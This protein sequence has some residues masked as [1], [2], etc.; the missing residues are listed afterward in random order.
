MKGRKNLYLFIALLLPICVFIFLKMFGRNEFTVAPLFV[1]VMPEVQPGCATVT[2][3]YHTPDSIVQKIDFR[4]DSL[5]LVSFGETTPEGV[6]QLKRV[7]EQ[8]Q[9]D[10][11]HQLHIPSSD[12]R[13]T[14]WRP[15]TFFLKEPFDL[16]LVDSKGV[17]RG[18]Y[19]SKD[20]DEMDRLI[21]EITIIL[22][23]Y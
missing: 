2:I 22:K 21:T 1:D 12:Y 20:L 13:Y 9:A 10:P 5:V 16:V 4:N 18:H 8:H 3:P 14:T 11:I 23:K 15:C 6:S 7:E 17:I 19:N